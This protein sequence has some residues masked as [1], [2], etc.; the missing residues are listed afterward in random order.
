M[1]LARAFTA[2][3]G[4][5]LA[6]V[7][8]SAQG[9]AAA[10]GSILEQKTFDGWDYG[11]VPPG[12]QALYPRESFDALRN[13]AEV[14]LLK[15]RY[16]SDGL[17]VGGFIARPKK[18]EGRL[19]VVV[20][21]RGGLADGLIG[22]TNF[23]YIQ[24]MMRYAAEG[25]VVVASQYRGV[26]GA[27]GHDEVGGADLHDVLNII[28]VA[29]GLPYADADRLFMWGYSR[30]AL[31]TLQLLRDGVPVRAAVLVG[32]PTD[33]RA[34]LPGAEG[35]FRQSF[36]DY[37]RRKDEHLRN[38]S[39]VLW[40]EK[41]D[42]PLLIL[43]GGADNL[44]PAHSLNLA[45]KLEEQGKVYELVVYQGDIH[46]VILNR[47]D[48]LRRTVDWF[49]HPRARSVGAALRKVVT[50]Q[51]AAAAVRR[52]HELK[53]T[54]ADRYDFSERELNELGYEL[55]GD[56]RVKEAVEIFKLNVEAFPQGFNTYDSLG[57]AYAVQGD[58]E[59]A[60][61]NYKKSLELNPQNTNAVDKLKELEKK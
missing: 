28:K 7:A 55:L 16:A 45:Q 31:M 50:E 58:K 24:E 6:F 14:E 4:L 12:L 30:G 47:E 13:S 17:S 5:C 43:H 39:P 37:D 29:R 27:G 32:P 2:L 52:Y 49:K 36:P 34:L 23:N 35:F 54:Q 48:R 56:G 38:R 3:A 21:N 9:P 42:T 59:L 11:Q 15:I 33:Y 44:S 46:P 18:A 10:D 40:V 41:I 51:G 53:R 1:K 8:A 20:F 57:E 61:K 25:F 22:M 60:I 26:D 19:P